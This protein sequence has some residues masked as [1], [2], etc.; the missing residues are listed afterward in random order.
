MITA[1]KR[2]MNHAPQSTGGPSPFL[3][4][5]R[6]IEAFE[7]SGKGIFSVVLHYAYVLLTYYS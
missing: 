4:G 2:V 6:W 5:S 1:K 7:S 3:R